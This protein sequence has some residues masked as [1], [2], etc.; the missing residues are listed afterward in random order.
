V[1]ERLLVPAQLATLKAQ[2]EDVIDMEKD[3]VWFYRLGSN[4]RP[5]I[6]SM[7]KGLRYEQDG[8]LML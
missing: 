4:W 2:L 7:G 6:E 5:K 1:F 8:V 3:S